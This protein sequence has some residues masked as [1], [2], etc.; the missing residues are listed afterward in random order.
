MCRADCKHKGDKRNVYRIFM[1]KKGRDYW[2]DLEIRGG[3]Y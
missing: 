2:K 3:Y 1:R